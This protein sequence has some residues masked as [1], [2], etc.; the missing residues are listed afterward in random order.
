[1]NGN[2]SRLQDPRT[3]AKLSWKKGEEIYKISVKAEQEN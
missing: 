1:M 2:L 3:T